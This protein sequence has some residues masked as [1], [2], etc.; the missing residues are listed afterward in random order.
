MLRLLIVASA[1]L[2][3]CA[4]SAEAKTTVVAS[5]IDNPRGLALGSDGTLY[6]ASAGHGGPTCRE[7]AG[8]FGATGQVLAFRNGRRTVVAS[9]LPS[10]T[11]DREGTFADGP[12]ALTFGAN[13]DLLTINTDDEPE[14]V[15]K[16]PRAAR[17]LAGTLM[18]VAPGPPTVLTNVGDQVRAFLLNA[19][20][21]DLF[22]DILISDWNASS[23]VPYGDG[24][25][26]A[27]SSWPAAKLD[28]N[29]VVTGVF[30]EPED[31]SLTFPAAVAADPR[32]DLLISALDITA[33]HVLRYPAI[34]GE[35]ELAYSRVASVFSMAFGPDG[36]LYLARIKIG[37][38]FDDRPSGSILRIAPDGKRTVVARGLQRPGGIVV[39]GTTIYV[40]DYAADVARPLAG[41]TKAITR[42]IAMLPKRHRKAARA[43]YEA[44][45]LGGRILK[46][47]P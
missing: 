25:A 43:R 35:P 19:D 18:R 2:L 46:I 34:G 45:R 17:S 22:R 9:G 26:V 28:A 7:K 11:L 1:L 12:S 47:T 10:Y 39:D 31:S 30:S 13:G 16:W 6:V 4:G 27:G 23:M 41:Q 42:E 40:T 32:G 37:L 14:H 3:G 44:H 21:P 33:P 8:C 29:G 15:A 5:G 36:S 20:G 38:P 24:F